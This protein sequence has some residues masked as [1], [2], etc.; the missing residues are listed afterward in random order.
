VLRG[1]KMFERTN[2]R[3]LGVVEN[4]SG[5]ICPCCGQLYEIFGRAGGRRLAEQTGIDFLGEIPL[6]IPVREG[7]DA[8]V[9]IVVGQP[10]SPAATALRA[11]A[12]AVVAR[13]EVP[14][15]LPAVGVP[16]G[17]PA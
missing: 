14:G 12:D 10:E 16:A 5:F 17:V 7:G 4:M 15:E 11:I 1:I 6:E 9:P 2:T 8:G 3:V 13:I